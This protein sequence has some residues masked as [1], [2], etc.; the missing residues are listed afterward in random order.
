MND[1]NDKVNNKAN[2]IKPAVVKKPQMC[3]AEITGLNFVR[4]NNQL[5]P[6]AVELLTHGGKS[7]KSVAVPE[8]RITLMPPPHPV[9]E[10][11]PLRMN[12]KEL[13]TLFLI[14]Q[15]VG[16]I[17]DPLPVE[18]C[19]FIEENIVLYNRS[20]KTYSPPTSMKVEFSRLSQKQKDD[21]KRAIEEL[22]T[23]LNEASNE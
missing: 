17:K 21:R 8:L 4:P 11:L 7:D 3:V 2:C 20:D 22:L 14:L 15:E 6:H 18:L 5:Y 9:H 19:K 13:A 1:V 10:P 16:F 12:K 23:K